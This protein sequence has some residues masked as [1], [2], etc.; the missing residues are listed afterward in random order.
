[1]SRAARAL[2]KVDLFGFRI[3]SGRKAFTPAG[4]KLLKRIMKK[5]S[6]HADL[7]KVLEVGS[8]E[9]K[10]YALV[11]LREVI[12]RKFDPIVRPIFKTHEGVKVNTCRNA[13]AN[14]EQQ[15][16]NDKVFCIDYG[17]YSYRSYAQGRFS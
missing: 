11:G 16:F 17:R 7:L 4:A 15:D 12:L 5:R 10:C 13:T 8:P 2:C 1:M 9:A 14:L 3:G 6:A